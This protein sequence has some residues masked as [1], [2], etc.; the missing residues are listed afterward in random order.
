M[1]RRGCSPT[2]GSNSITKCVPYH[3]VYASLPRS[4]CQI[5]LW[6]SCPYNYY[7][8]CSYSYINII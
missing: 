5:H 1:T 7:V 8:V 6:T 2:Q 4:R 3:T